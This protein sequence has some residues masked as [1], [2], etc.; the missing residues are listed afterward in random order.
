M[1]IVNF[2]GI[3]IALVLGILGCDEQLFSSKL[4]ESGTGTPAFS[5][6][7]AEPDMSVEDAAVDAMSPDV[8][9][10][11][12]ASPPDIT[13]T[14]P[15][16][17][18]QIE[19]SLPLPADAT[20]DGQVFIPDAGAVEPLSRLTFHWERGE[21]RVSEEVSSLSLWVECVDARGAEVQS[22]FTEEGPSDVAELFIDIWYSD[23]SQI[24]TCYITLLENGALARNELPIGVGTYWSNNNPSQDAPVVIDRDSLH[25]GSWSAKIQ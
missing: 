21:S 23:Q 20:T 7:D 8:L 24:S 14:L 17:S 13:P 15:D 19:D 10:E 2:T 1:K 11:E 6:E 4:V 25:F 5:T 18:A 22:F 9:F 12:D 16:M 3:F